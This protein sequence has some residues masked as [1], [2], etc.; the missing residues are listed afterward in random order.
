MKMLVYSDLHLDHGP[1]N[2][3][4]ENG[5]RV[6]EQAD[7]VVLAGDINN[8]ISGIKWGRE[9]FPDKPILYVMGNHEFYGGHW[10]RTLERARELATEFDVHL[11]ENDSLKVGEVTFL[12]ATLWTDFRLF[13]EDRF[14]AFS[15][16]RERM[17][18]YRQIKISRSAEMYWVKSKNLIP[19]LTSRRHRRSLEWMDSQLDGADPAKTVIISHHAPHLKSIPQE[20]KEDILSCCYASDLS[21]YMGKAKLWIHGHVHESVDYHLNGTRVISNPRGYRLRTGKVQNP[22]FEMQLLVSV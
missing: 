19:D 5:I 1:F 11:L 17:N 15:E 20:Y 4:L 3:I 13:G 8:G 10:D 6:D 22:R 7:L 16:A 9:A 14:A 21:R 12:G 2:P 18:D